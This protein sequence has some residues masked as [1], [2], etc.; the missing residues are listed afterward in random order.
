MDEISLGKLLQKARKQAGLTQQELCQRAGLSYSTLAKIE[1]GAIRAPS[2]FTIQ[3]VVG[4]LGTTLDG[5]LG[6]LPSAGQNTPQTPKKRSQSGVSF[7]YF[8]V[9]GCLVR[10]Y[11]RAFTRIAEDSGRPADVVESAFWHLNDAACRG[12]L[13]M[14]EFNR[15]LGAKFDLPDFD[16]SSY[17]LTAVEPIPPMHE[18]VA[19]ASR[20]YRIGL[21]TNIMPG[22]V[23]A[24]LARGLLP[25]APYAVVID[26]SIVHA[27]KPETAI[28]E[29]AQTRS[30][31]PPME[32]LLVDD[33]RPNI[34]AAEKLGWKVLWF[35]DYRPE[36]SVARVR[37]ALKF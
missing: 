25:P 16:W 1:R 17:Y 3:S 15:D 18:L 24:M 34:M 29:I 33:S 20:H 37:D 5:L 9:N 32:I 6:E 30:G 11:H 27:I 26:S 28:Y 19:W 23:D 36:E 8:D 35:D 10:F 22:L 2:I 14:A 7:V 31:V 13:T 4:A 12:D 21:L